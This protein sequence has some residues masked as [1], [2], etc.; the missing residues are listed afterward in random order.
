M[1]YRSIQPYH[2]ISIITFFLIKKYSPQIKVSKD[3]WNIGKL[4]LSPWIWR[5][6]NSL[7]SQKTQLFLILHNAKFP[8]QNVMIK[9]DFMRPFDQH[10]FLQLQLANTWISTI[11]SH[12]NQQILGPALSPPIP[13]K[14]SKLTHVLASH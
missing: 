14:I 1:N 6:L 12:S 7:F 8:T 11:S 2:F 13:T 3:Y 9:I 10:Y 4:Y 5:Y